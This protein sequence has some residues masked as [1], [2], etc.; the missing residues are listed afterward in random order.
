MSFTGN[1]EHLPIV[2][3]IQLLHATRK[4]GTLNVRCRK[5]E[6][7]LVFKDGYIVSAN[8]VDLGVR[9]G[10]ILVETGVITP[11]ILDQALQNQILAGAERKPLIATLA[12]AG[13]VNAEGAFNCLEMLIEMTIV[14]ILTWTK[15][16][17][18]LDVQTVAVAD[19]YRYFPEHLQ[20]EMNLDTQ[21]V[22]M[23]ALRIFDEKV[24]DGELGP[25]DGYEEEP[26]DDPPVTMTTAA[27]ISADDLGLA[28]LDRLERKI[29]QVFASI[30]EVDNAREHRQ[31]IQK[32]APDLAPAE[33]ER[34]V[35]F[36]AE[37][38]RP[39]T[40]ISARGGATQ[41][42]ILYSNDDLLSHCLTA[43]CQ[44]DRTIVF[45]T[46][47]EGDLETTVD[48]FLAKRI[49][50]ILVLDV[51]T[52]SEATHDDAA[53]S[54]L[55]R[56]LLDKAPE[57]AIVQLAVPGEARFTL[58]A[59]QDG[60]RAVFPKP[61]REDRSDSFV[62]ETI[63]LLEAFHDYLKSY[64]R[65]RGATPIG[66]LARCVTALRER[67]E[68]PAVALEILQFVAELCGRAVT[69]IVG[70]DELVAER[71]IG[72]IAD[73]GNGP[74]PALRF[75]IPL[76]GP[77]TFRKAIDDGRTFFGKADETVHRLLFGEIGAPAS[78]TVLLLPLR[79]RGKTIAL[80]YGDF[81]QNGEES[82]DID[83][84]EI[85]ASQAGLV[86]ENAVY[87]KRLAQRSP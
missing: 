77:S 7:Q 84:L 31:A 26:A 75:R 8:H 13:H 4:T 50:L 67:P 6:S 11:E 82:I 71:G 49:S 57:L 12:E 29:P 68:A 58:D 86:L 48:R 20:R 53:R 61:L 56:R 59:L 44:R 17:F 52:S 34:L 81:G 23:E 5:G 63:H 66:R 83:L 9:I 27:I 46:G 1:L 42:V 25:V 35:N 72:I 87:R 41:A 85:L 45:T 54:R 76:A 78:S 14:E 33:Q 69:L 60:S 62:E 16:T 15:G 10:N 21:S 28:D 40:E 73:G 55:R 18:S 64:A 65:Q 32:A 79:S 24:R 3:V 36:L 39:R 19:E 43:V 30:E 22:L 74:S 70:Q 51:P 38:A 47:E 37:A 80:I 2:D